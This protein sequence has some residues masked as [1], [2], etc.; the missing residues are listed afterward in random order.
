MI[1]TICIPQNSRT[2]IAAA[3]A[4]MPDDIT[5]NHFTHAALIRFRNKHHHIV[6]DWVLRHEYFN[7]TELEVLVTIYFKLLYANSPNA[8]QITRMQYRAVLHAVFDMADDHLMDRIIHVLTK[9]AFKPLVSLDAWLETMAL[10]LRG[11][12]AERTTFC[13]AVYDARGKNRIKRKEII[14]LMKPSLWEPL[15]E[16]V[17]ETAKDLADMMMKRM[18][19]DVDYCVSYKDY[20]GTVRSNPLW[21]E[22]FGQCL[23]AVSA[24]DAFLQTFR[25]RGGKFRDRRLWHGST[26]VDIYLDR[27]H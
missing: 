25:L 23:P 7:E 8:T 5:C 1:D 16:D 19:L 12:P 21:L 14:E 20:A 10:F 22:C 15:A 2:P 9:G 6:R 3:A 4:K 26:E 17:E 13:Y 27:I 18:D 11:S 24:V